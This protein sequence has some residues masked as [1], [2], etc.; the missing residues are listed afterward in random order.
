MNKKNLT[1]L[2]IVLALGIGLE[3]VKGLKSLSTDEQ[4]PASA[5]WGA[6][7]YV[8]YS[9]RNNPRTS[10]D[11]KKTVIA[12]NRGFRLSGGPAKSAVNSYDT[13]EGH[14]IKAEKD[15]AKAAK[16]AKSSRGKKKK[17]E[18]AKKN[19]MTEIKSK[20]TVTEK[21]S[22]TVDS[23]ETQTEIVGGAIVNPEEKKS[24]PT[25]YE[26]WARLILNGPK[27][28]Q[29]QALIESYRN[30]RITS[31]VFYAILNAMLND[32]NN[33]QNTLAVEAAGSVVEPQS[34]LFLV[35]VLKTKNP[36]AEAFTL[37]QQNINEYKSAQTIVVLRGV[38]TL[39][40]DDAY[41]VLL[42]TQLLNQSLQ[43]YLDSR[44][45]ADT[46]QPPAATPSRGQ[47]G[48]N[49]A[50]QPG[51]NQTNIG[52]I[53]KTFEPVLNRIVVQ[54]SSNS[55]IVENATQALARIQRLT[56]TNVIASEN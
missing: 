29:V 42:V 54:F 13:S 24:E 47:I 22:N 32:K 49:S 53:Y 40:N 34:F 4:T 23:N 51:S 8:P 15:S 35:Q 37:A 56:P 9:L 7:D 46:S 38:F 14:G 3:L 48:G 6:V 30:G 17:S 25:T 21:K 36:G 16:K 11:I 26:D 5:S 44:T 10:R 43:G 52:G 55:E 50:L 12:K 2:A 33:E 41:T 28:E 27:P 31:E 20:E 39:A 1:I 18:I 19:R 45:P